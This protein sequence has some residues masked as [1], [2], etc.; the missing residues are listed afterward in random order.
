MR[1]FLTN[2][3]GIV[4]ISVFLSIISSVAAL[5]QP[6][7]I[8]NVVNALNET[9]ALGNIVPNMDKIY[10]N[11]W[12][13]V[14]VGFIALFTGVA[15][16]IYAAKIAQGVGSDMRT[17]QF[18]KIQELATE[19]IE[20]F[21][22]SNLI[23]RLT[24]DI[25]QVQN[26]IMQAFQILI[27]IP[28]LFFGAFILATIAFPQLWWTIILYVVIVALMLGLVMGRAVPIFRGMQK[29]VDQINTV[30]KENMDGVRVV[31]SFV[32]EEKE[33][34]K[35]DKL[36]IALTDKII[37]TGSM[38]SVIV[39]GFMFAANIV[40][41]IAI[42]LTAGWAIDDP[43]L[44]GKLIS[45]TTYMMQI[46]FALIMGGML[47]VTLSRAQVSSKRIEEVL[48]IEPSI[49]NEVELLYDIEEIEF[50]DVCFKYANDEHQ[51]ISNVSFKLKKGD[52]LGIIGASGSGKSTIVSLLS[53]FYE[54]QSGEI[55]INGQSIN[56][57]KESELAKQIGVVLQKAII[58]SGTI[59]DNFLQGK[60]DATDEEILL[61]A[62]HAQAY[63]FILKKEGQLD[64]H[65]FEKGA[66]FSGGQKQRL[67]IGR[68]LVKKPNLL[69]LDDAT[70]ALDARS[71]RLVK[72]ALN[73]E[74]GGTT[75]IIV[76]QKISSI[77]DMDKIVVLDE[78]KMVGI[79]TH[80]ELVRTNAI[81]QEIYET[82]KA[83]EVIKNG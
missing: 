23:V 27:R 9:D 28:I 78:G 45:F 26:F 81:Y 21:S 19:D 72:E 37:K 31:K 74:M 47:M 3:K 10:S 50:N 35:F 41:A 68:A 13:L 53:H 34:T 59:R 55:L 57:Y 17:E 43:A 51:T 83:R 36:V 30:V 25:T 48:A 18:K 61:A 77:I 1:R 79:G 42:Y 11:G 71:E 5:V 8:S 54:P 66:N 2:Y 14:G 73:R 62:K 15:N 33:K 12:F 6:Q 76:S 29:D 56:K 69:I 46:M 44:I 40:T 24:N 64:E 32:T 4:R 39:P 75:T 7:L 63:E 67:S 38:F 82:Q 20:K 70:S 52:R 22:S 49:S 16:S 65:V 58:F 80:D 60:P